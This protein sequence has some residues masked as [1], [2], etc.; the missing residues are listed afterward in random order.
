MSIHKNIRTVVILAAMVFLLSQFH[1]PNEM[2]YG[3]VEQE[4]SMAYDDPFFVTQVNP[5]NASHKT[6]P[7]TLVVVTFNRTI[8][9]TTVNSDTFTLRGS[10]TGDYSGIYSQISNSI[11]FDS[12]Q[13]FKVGEKIVATL[14]NGI[15]AADG[16]PLPP[17]TW[18]FRITVD[19]GSGVFFNSGEVF[20]NTN[21]SP[22]SGIGDLDNDG[23]LDVIV[24]THDFSRVF[25]NDGAGN[26]VDSGQSLSN[27]WGWQIALGD[28]DKDGDLDA[29]VGDHATGHMV[30]MNNGAGFFIDSG[31]VLGNGQTYGIALGDVDG[32]GDL[33]AVAANYNGNAIWLNNGSGVF[34]HSNQFLGA[35]GIDVALGDIDG[36]WDLDLFF[37]NDIYNT[38]G[39]P[40][41]VWLNN[42]SGIFSDSGQRLGY[43]EGVSVALGD[44]D[45]DGDL[46]A[47]VANEDYQPDKVWL[48]N[49]NGVFTDSGQNLASA[50][51]LDVAIGDI[52]NDGDLDA[53]VA[54]GF[55]SGHQADTNKVWLNNGK[56]N[57]YQSVQGFLPSFCGTAILGDVDDDGDMDVLLNYETVELWKNGNNVFRIYLPLGIK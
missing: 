45:N 17:Y 44:L 11:Q 55:A 21:D 19:G 23:D 48:N 6:A 13:D 31:Q 28:L 54:T 22:G 42:G 29:Y 12:T 52:D 15:Q 3:G 18:E 8:D 47:F 14:S 56:G 46:D 35:N 16:T 4:V 49:G 34:T 33:D 9:F 40:A 24:V 38:N 30:W 53:L 26:F 7:D 36:D 25:F 5:P 51:S 43:S 37:V 39:L 1:T 41:T 10:L 2:A 27:T 32:D 57:F 20:S 50:Y